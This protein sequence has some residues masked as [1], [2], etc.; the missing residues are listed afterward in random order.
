[1]SR[2]TVSNQEL[3]RLLDKIYR[4]GAQVGSGSTAAAVRQELATGLPISNRYHT[5]KAEESIVSL[6]RWLQ[7][8]STA[9]P[10]DR[11]AAENVIRDLQDALAGN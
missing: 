3:S 7:N 2:P 6:E 4:E 5:Q 11:A 8:N 10:G 9:R 1:M